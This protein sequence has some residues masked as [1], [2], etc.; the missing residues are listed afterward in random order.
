MKIPDKLRLFAT[1][2]MAVAA[3]VMAI[4]Y[5]AYLVSGSV[6]L[7]SDALESIVNVMTAVAALIALSQPSPPTKITRLGIIRPSSLRRSLKA[8]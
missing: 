5:V 8:R 7:Y 4:K 6:A 1:I 2:N 3:A